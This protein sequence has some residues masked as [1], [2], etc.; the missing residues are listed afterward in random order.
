MLIYNADM[1]IQTFLNPNHELS[2]DERLRVTNFCDRPVD[3][4]Q[5]EELKEPQTLM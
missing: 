2:W 3:K 1:Y 5:K 4:G